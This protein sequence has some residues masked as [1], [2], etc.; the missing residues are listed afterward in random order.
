MRTVGRL[1]ILLLLVLSTAM[2]ALAQERLTRSARVA[3]RKFWAVAAALNTAMV[4]DTKSTFDVV[5][6][7]RM[8]REANPFV[9][10]FV[11]RGPAVTFVAGEVFDAGVM[12]IAAKMKASDRTWV[13]RTWWVMPAAL[14][15]G[16]TIALRHNRNLLK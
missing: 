10:P 13:R 2:P 3:D 1:S 16:H 4:L 8:C 15:V 6:V 14:G 12:S 9:A 5:N 7:C 11:R